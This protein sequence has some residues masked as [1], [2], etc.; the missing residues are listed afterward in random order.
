MTRVLAVI[1]ACAS[2]AAGAQT[3]PSKPV[4]I[5]VPF[6]PG[7]SADITSRL[8]GDRMA[9]GLGQPVLIENKESRQRTPNGSTRDST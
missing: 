3:F 9:E 8:L 4:R 6:P 2:F 1:I 7:G 5:V